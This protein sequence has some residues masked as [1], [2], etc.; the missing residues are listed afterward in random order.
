MQRTWIC[1][2]LFIEEAHPARFK[3]ESCLCVRIRFALFQRV[4]TTLPCL[5]YLPHLSG[6]NAKLHRREFCKCVCSQ[7]SPAGPQV[8]H[9]SH[10]QAQWRWEHRLRHLPDQRR[11]LVQEPSRRLSTWL[12]RVSRLMRVAAHGHEPHVQVR[13]HRLRRDQ[14]PLW[15]RLLGVDHL[16]QVLPEPLRLRQLLQ[17]FTAL[18][19]QGPGVEP[20]FLY[21]FVSFQSYPFFLDLLHFIIIKNTNFSFKN[22]YKCVF[23]PLT[24]QLAQ[25]G[26]YRQTN[27]LL[28]YSGRN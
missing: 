9:K 1:S 28:L 22:N 20:I 24:H 8:R 6:A 25:G 21:C 17:L 2:V 27:F 18:P 13:P 16:R 19:V 10:R 15:E 12:Q 4:F 14:A 3:P 11:L 26:T 23:F 7:F 5:P